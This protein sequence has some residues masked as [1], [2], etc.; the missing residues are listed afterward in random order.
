MGY[1][2]KQGLIIAC[3]AAAVV[4]TCAAHQGRNELPSSSPRAAA[5]QKSLDQTVI[6]KVDLENVSLES[7]LKTWHE[8]SRDSHPQHFDFRYAI[9]HPTT[10][11]SEPARQGASAASASNTAK[12]SVRRKNITS[13]RL[14]DEICQQANVSWVIMGRVIVVQPRA[15]ASGTQ[16]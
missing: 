1:P 16:P 8:A 13:A 14:L 6:P 7:A 15:T 9:S 3:V 11:S 2:V 4:S 5:I 12:I 10:F